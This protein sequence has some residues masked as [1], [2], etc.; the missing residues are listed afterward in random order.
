ML[1]AS[2]LC[3]A[4]LQPLPRRA[5]VGAATAAL[6]C[7]PGRAS[8]A[9][10]DAADVLAKGT[11]RVQGGVEAAESP[12]AALYVTVRVVPQNNVGRY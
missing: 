10:S 1:L 2:I 7:S 12:T 4:A 9:L 5:V 8:A 11:V 6:L 3:A